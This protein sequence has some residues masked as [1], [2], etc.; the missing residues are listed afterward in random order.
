MRGPALPI[1]T[2]SDLGWGALNGLWDTIMAGPHMVGSL[3]TGMINGMPAGITANGQA[4]Y[5]NGVTDPVTLSPFH[6]G[7]PNSILYQTGYYGA[8]LMVA[9]GASS[10]SA[11]SAAAEDTAVAAA[12]GG[13]T[14]SCR[15]TTVD[16]SEGIAETYND[17]RRDRSGY[18]GY[19]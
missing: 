17:G 7:N 4:I 13:G 12:R 8:P 2:P 1:G 5:V 16:A 3:L 10:A 14:G 6:H 15:R 11:L 18:S 9:A 19:A